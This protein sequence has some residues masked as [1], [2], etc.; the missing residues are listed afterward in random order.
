MENNTFIGMDNVIR[1]TY[2][3]TIDNNILYDRYI[4]NL[5][6]LIY[7]YKKEKNYME[8]K[9]KKLTSENNIL[10]LHINFL[11]KRYCLNI[12]HNN[13][14]NFVIKN[15]QGLKSLL[16]NLIYIYN[17]N[18]YSIVLIKE[19]IHIIN[20]NINKYN[21]EILNAKIY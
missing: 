15:F 21:L 11:N 6:E 10:L 8:Y 18:S 7:E 4:Y 20:L 9:L 1:G 3:S 2:D 12:K 14:I 16:D 17:E 19:K 5:Q 13:T